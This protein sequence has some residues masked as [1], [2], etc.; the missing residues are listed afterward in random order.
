MKNVLSKKVWMTGVTHPHVDPPPIPLIQETYD[1]KTGKYFI[2]TGLRRDPTS[3]TSY[4][5][6][7]KI[8]LFDNDKP[9]EFLLFVHNFN[10]TIT[11]S[12]NLEAGAK[13]QYLRTVVRGAALRQFN[14]FSAVIESTQILNVEDIIKGLAHYLFSVNS[15][16]KQKCSMRRGMENPR[17]LTVRRYAAHLID[18]ND[19]LASFLGNTLNA[20]IGITELKQILLNSVPNRWSKHAYVQVFDCGSIMF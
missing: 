5:Y 11:A 3:S 14:F 17:A 8:S 18:I 7:F 19:Y 12:R 10:M 6:K 2:K 15:L 20:K 1:D 13:V 4:L 9:E 16:S